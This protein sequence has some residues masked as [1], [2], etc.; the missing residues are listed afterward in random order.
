MLKKFTAWLQFLKSAKG[1]TL[2]SFDCRGCMAHD[3]HETARGVIT[4]SFYRTF[5]DGSAKGASVLLY[6]I[7]RSDGSHFYEVAD[8]CQPGSESMAKQTQ[9]PNERLTGKIVALH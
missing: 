9:N 6:E 5:Y 8:V 3:W 1:K 4:G 2:I 7:T